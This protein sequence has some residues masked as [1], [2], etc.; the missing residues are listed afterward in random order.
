VWGCD[1]TTDTETGTKK[2]H[3]ARACQLRHA[4][5]ARCVDV[6][7]ITAE[8]CR[9]RHMPRAAKWGGAGMVFAALC[10]TRTSH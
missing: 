7:R 6:D 4:W 1:D 3:R 5:T 8:D 10:E 9:S 2:E